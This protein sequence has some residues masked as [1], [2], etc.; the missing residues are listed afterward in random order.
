MIGHRLGLKFQSE[1][2]GDPMRSLAIGLL[3]AVSLLALVVAAPSLGRAS[4]LQNSIEAPFVEAIRAKLVEKFGASIEADG[5]LSASPYAQ[6]MITR[7][8]V[9]EAGL[10]RLQASIAVSKAIRDDL[11]RTRQLS[12]AINSER[13]KAARRQAEAERV[14]SWPL[15]IAEDDQE[16]MRQALAMRARI[17]GLEL[18]EAAHMIGTLQ[19]VASEGDVVPPDPIEIE[20]LADGATLD[21]LKRPSIVPRETPAEG[22]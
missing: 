8:L 12:E 9:D 6:R 7:A 19:A 20:P 2:R 11:R 18:A 13:S 21:W 4:S 15:Q 5:S 10:T 22:V 14:K 3:S 16:F 1:R 17:E